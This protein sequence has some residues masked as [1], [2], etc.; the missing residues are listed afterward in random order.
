LAFAS[1]G[2]KQGISYSAR[3]SKPLRWRR[4]GLAIGGSDVSAASA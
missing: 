3:R 1:A 4:L 2:T